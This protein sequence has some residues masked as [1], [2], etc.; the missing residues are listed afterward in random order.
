VTDDEILIHGN[1]TVKKAE[2]AVQN[3]KDLKATFLILCKVTDEL[4]ECRKTKPLC[5]IADKVLHSRLGTTTTRYRSITTGQGSKSE[6]SVVFRID[7]KL[8]SSNK[9]KWDAVDVDTTSRKKL[10]FLVEDK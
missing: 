4:I 6:K 2:G 1:M 8:V 10:Q 5:A 7:L 3:N 9:K